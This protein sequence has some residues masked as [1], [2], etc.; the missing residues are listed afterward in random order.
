MLKLISRRTAIKR[1]SFESILSHNILRELVPALLAHKDETSGGSPDC[2]EE[3]FPGEV[4]VDERGFCADAPESEPYYAP[5]ATRIL[6]QMDLGTDHL[7]PNKHLRVH[8]IHRHNF[9]L[10]YPLRLQPRRILKHSLICL[11]ISIRFPLK[12]NPRMVRIGALRIRFQCIKE[13]IVV[14][15]IMSLRA[16]NLCSKQWLY[17][18]PVV[19]YSVSRIEVG[20]TGG[21]GWQGVR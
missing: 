14:A 7:T 19:R 21:C 8:K 6:H 15:S 20:K 3:G 11:R 18:S 13:I 10:H 4:V 1:H 17:E 12:D 2:V 9:I 5:L 16:N